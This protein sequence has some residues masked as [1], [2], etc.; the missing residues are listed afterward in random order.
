M[1]N[2]LI[3]PVMQFLILQG[4]SKETKASSGDDLGLKGIRI[5]EGIDFTTPSTEQLTAVVTTSHQPIVPGTRGLYNLGNTC[6]F[7]SIL[8]ILMHIEDLCLALR[9]IKLFHDEDDFV[10]P[11]PEEKLVRRFVDT[12]SRQWSADRYSPI[13]PRKLLKALSHFDPILFELGVQQDAHEA[14]I[15]TSTLLS[16]AIARLFPHSTEI[17]KLFEFQVSRQVIC[18]NGTTTRLDATADSQILIPLP[19]SNDPVTM[20]S[21]IRVAFNSQNFGKLSA[22]SHGDLEQGGI[23]TSLFSTFPKLLLIVAHRNIYGSSKIRTAIQYPLTFSLNDVPREIESP[24]YQLKGVVHHRGRSVQSG[25]YT[26]EYRHPE[27]GQWYLAND[28]EVSRIENPTNDSPTAY[29]F[30]YSS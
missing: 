13:N 22:C 3:P 11:S 4:C 14:L 1:Y 16:D 12:F 18:N 29:I 8:Q 21:A 24:V 7:N 26:A 19:V 27:T 5:S 6:Y 23:T 28:H 10:P 20:Q 30:L 25:H 9:S 15:V 2:K 17:H